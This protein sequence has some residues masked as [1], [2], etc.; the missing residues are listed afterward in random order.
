GLWAALAGLACATASAGSEPAQAPS[1]GRGRHPRSKKERARTSGPVRNPVAVGAL[2]L[3]VAAAL[4]WAGRFVWAD[5]QV[6][7]GL[8][9]ISSGDVEGGAARVESAADFRAE[10][11]YDRSLGEE[12]G[13]VAV[14]TEDGDHLARAEA[15]YSY[16][17]GLPHLQGFVSLGRVLNDAATFEPEAEARA[18]RAYAEALDIDPLNPLLRVEYADVLNDLDRPEEAIEILEP[19][20]R[21]GGD[22]FAQVWGALA[23][24]RFNSGDRDGAEEAMERAFALDPSEPQARAVEE[25]LQEDG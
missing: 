21:I 13:E 9:E 3:P 5:A 18:Q 4:W 2:V 14:A 1:P 17:D 25:A 11:T 7:R 22:E 19:A 8:V 12:L 23:I 15:A 20:V 10:P 24:A 6:H 16:L